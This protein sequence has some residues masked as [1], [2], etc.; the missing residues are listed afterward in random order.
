[1]FKPQAISK[2]A[3]VGVIAPASPV[4]KEFMELG[5]K[6]LVCQGLDVR[7]ANNV[8]EKG[9]Y[10]A[11]NPMQRLEDLITLWDDPKIEAV[12]CARGGYGSME[13]LP[14]LNAD[15]LSKCPKVFLGSSDVTAIHSFLSA[16]GVVSFY[17]PMVAQKIARSAYDASSLLRLIRTTEPFGL[18]RP[19]GTE[20]LHR[21][22]G[23]GKLIGGC[24][25]ILASL[26]GTPF[27]PD[28][29]D[30]ILFLEDTFVKPYQIDRML[31]QFRLSGK[32]DCVRGII[33]GQMLGCEQHPEQGYT[34]QEMLREWTSKMGV[35]VLYGFPVGHTNLDALTLP[36]GIRARLDDAGLTLLEGAV[37]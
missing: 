36:L 20:W 26:I 29:K 13:L 31:M 37:C 18:I 14:F 4:R 16:A 33:F 15:H 3:Q 9:R 30:T 21:G 2:N 22:V 10:T 7:F 34:L 23:E 32:F 27:L 28:F 1:M 8:Y 12:F 6:E 25:S 19:V 17:G 35:P 24:L 11:G 5:K